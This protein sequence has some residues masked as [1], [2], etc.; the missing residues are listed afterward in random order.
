MG[1]R[2]VRRIPSDTDESI[3]RAMITRNGGEKT[4]LPAEVYLPPAR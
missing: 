1:D 4:M 3:I 2:S